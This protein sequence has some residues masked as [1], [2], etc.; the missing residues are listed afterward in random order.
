MAPA[1]S[2][3]WTIAS[4]RISWALSAQVLLGCRTTTESAR[5]SA[6]AQ[7]PCASKV[8]PCASAFL[9]RSAKRLALYIPL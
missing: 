2:F 5:T 4:P 9:A 6:C 1:Q 3:R 7:Y 8:R